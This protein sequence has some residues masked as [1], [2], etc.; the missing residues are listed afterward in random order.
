[1]NIQLFPLDPL[2]SPPHLA[3]ALAFSFF[4]GFLLLAV[5]EWVLQDQGLAN[6][7]EVGDHPV[8]GDR[9]LEDDGPDPDHDGHD[10]AHHLSHRG[11][12]RLRH[13]QSRDV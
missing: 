9:G 8:K 6:L 10:I 13:R 7:E 12:G 1:M 4:L 2:I 5:L 3:L 11:L